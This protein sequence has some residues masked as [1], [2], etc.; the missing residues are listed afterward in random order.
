MAGTACVK[1]GYCRKAVLV[2][3]L[4][5]THAGRVS[6]LH[7]PVVLVTAQLVNSGDPWQLWQLRR[8]C[9]R[10]LFLVPEF[11]FCIYIRELS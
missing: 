11:R 2:V 6:N 10:W 5:G 1:Y 9:L 7:K 4:P 3:A 8:A